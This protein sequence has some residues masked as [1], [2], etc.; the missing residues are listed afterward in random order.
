MSCPE[1]KQEDIMDFIL[2]TNGS[3]VGEKPLVPVCITSINGRFQV[4]HVRME[5]IEE[6]NIYNYTYPSIPSVY[7]PLA[8]D[9]QEESCITRAQSAPSLELSGN[10][11]IIGFVDS[12]IDLESEMFQ[13]EGGGTRVVTLWDQTG[14]EEDTDEVSYGR[15]YQRNQINQ[16]LEA[17]DAE[18]LPRD[19][20]GHGSYLAGIAAATIGGIANQADIA[21]VKL[22]QCKTYLKE[23]YGIPEDTVCYQEND[24]MAGVQFL[25][26]YAQERGKPLI[27]CFCL[28]T[29]QG[30]HTGGS[31]LAQ[32]L[33][34]IARESGRAVICPTGNEALRRHHYGGEIAKQGET[35]RVEIQVEEGQKGF[36]LECWTSAPQ[37]FSIDI[38]SPTGE[39][40]EGVTLRRG[41]GEKRYRFNVEGT[42]VEQ[43]VR[44]VLSEN[45]Q[46]V[47]C[48]RFVDPTPGIWIL[49]VQGK[50]VTT[51][52]YNLW[53][54]M[55][56]QM[57]KQTIF[58]R[59][60]PDITITEPGNAIAIMTVAAYDGN[61]GGVY[62]QSGR[63]YTGSGQIKPD[64]AA[65]GVDIVSP[66]RE[67]IKSSTCASAAIA[68]GAAA[69]YMQWIYY[70]RN[71]KAITGVALKYGLVL[72]ATG[73]EEYTY[74]NREWGYGKL[75]LW[76]SLRV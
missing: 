75:C 33:N 61:T 49:E 69:L 32:L 4:Y 36:M 16:R 24:I 67:A 9:Y 2:E 59:S 58:I 5:D 12:G 10:G 46:Q 48:S 1:A 37:S 64:L 6:L 66:Y 57:G 3:Y 41:I 74:P 47:I 54:P 73:R 18:G 40:M 72:G 22:R 21:V 71:N 7:S 65:P 27:L 62:I 34:Q 50:V 38:V 23:Y 25:D 70:L 31:F 17:G 13:F 44:L 53:L 42:T 56:E 14:E 29:N 55:E 28:G 76:N 30:S 26:N 51:G 43:A 19:E 52:I 15:V 63:G 8:T 20:I 39:C 11:V 45:G 68:V 60:N 35:E